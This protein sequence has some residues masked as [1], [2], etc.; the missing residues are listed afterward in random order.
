MSLSGFSGAGVAER[1]PGD[2]LQHERLN[3]RVP[4]GH[5]GGAVQ[6]RRDGD[7]PGFQ[8]GA[9]FEAAGLPGGA[10]VGPLL[11]DPGG[12]GGDVDACGCRNPDDRLRRC[13]HR[14]DQPPGN[15]M[16]AQGFT[17]RQSRPCTR[18][19]QIGEQ[20]SRVAERTPRTF[21]WH[22]ASAH[23]LIRA[24]RAGASAND[25]GVFT[26]ADQRGPALSSAN[27]SATQSAMNVLTW[28][29][30]SRPMCSVA[31]SSAVKIRSSRLGLATACS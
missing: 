17:P 9:V 3:L 6:D 10:V 13:P 16:S 29:R 4:N 7:G 26:P 21:R 22:A 31:P 24:C 23:G 30:W 18:S 28:G 27:V 20:R 19:G 5:W 12:G 25:H 15:D 14:A 8:L 2:R 11:A 1:V